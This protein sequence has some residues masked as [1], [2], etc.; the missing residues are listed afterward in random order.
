MVGAGMTTLEVIDGKTGELVPYEQATMTLFG[1][2]DPDKAIGEAS[3]YAKALAKVVNQQKL[4]TQIGQSKH[5]R[6]EGW[7]TLGAMT[8]VFAIGEGEPEPVEINGVGGFKATVV[9]TRNGE[10]IGRATAYCMRDEERWSKQPTHAVASMAQTRATSKAL[11]G[12][13]GFIVKLAGYSSTPAEEMSGVTVADDIPFGDTTADQPLASEAQAKNIWRLI[14]KL[15]KAGTLD[16]QTILE[17]MGKEYGTES[18]AELYKNQASDLITRLKA[19]AG[20][21]D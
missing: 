14:N 4:F 21:D 7:Q 15:D 1:T 18:P 19:K 16:K 5:I 20:E 6:V 3:H 9:A 8:G 11:K 13:L 17:A 12:P 2:L 10:I